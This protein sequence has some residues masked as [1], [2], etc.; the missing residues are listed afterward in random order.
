MF[1]D[2]GGGVEKEYSLI[3]RELNGNCWSM[4]EFAFQ[5]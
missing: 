4:I 5:A 2:G 3:Q 1:T